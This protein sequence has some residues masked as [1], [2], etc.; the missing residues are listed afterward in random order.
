MTQKCEQCGKGG[1]AGGPLLTCDSCDHGYHGTCVEPPQKTK[2]DG[3]WNCPRCLVGDGNFGFEEGGLYSLKQFQEK[4]SDFKVGYFEN[5]MPFDPVLNCLRPVTEDDVEREFW[6]LVADL[7]ETV[8]VEYGADIHCTTHG[9]GFPTSERNPDN[10]Y[11]TDPWNLNILPLHPESLFRYIKSDISGMT[12][13]WVYVG[14]IFSTFCWHAEDHWAYS[15]NYQHFGATKTWYGIPGEDAEK[16]EA[17]MREAVPE[18]FE[19]QPDLLFQ[20]VT[21]LTPEQLKKAGVRVYALDQRAGQ[22]VITFPRAYHAGFNHGFNFNEA[23]NFAP[24]DW[25]P[26][27]LLGVQ[28]LRHFRRQPCFSHDELLWTAAE[29]IASAGLT[30][31]TAKWLYPALEKIHQREVAERELF[32][33]RH[34]AHEHK[35]VFNGSSVRGNEECP[36]TF[37]IDDAEVPEEEYG[38]AYCKAYTFLSR[39]KCLKSG[40]VLCLTHAGDHP[41]CDAREAD[42][43]LGKNHVLFYRKADN[44]IAATLRKVEDKAHLPEAWM[45][46]YERLL[47]EEA[48]P[49]LKA[50]RGLLADGEK[51]PYELPQLPNLR[52]FVERCNHWVEE[53]MGY[54]LRKQQNRRKSEKLWPSSSRK[55]IGHG[56]HEQKERELR[57]VSNVYRLL[58]EAEQIGFDCPEIVQLQERAEAI[59]TFQANAKKALDQR[60]A[61][62]AQQ[63]EELLEEGQAFSVDIPEVERLTGLLERLRWDEKARANRGVFMSLDE[64]NQLIEDGMRLQIPSYNDHM[65]HYREQLSLGQNWERKAQEVINAETIHFPQLQ[66]LSEQAQGRVLP[67]SADTLAKV[68]QIL[69]K[70]REAHRHIVD[71]NQRLLEPDYRKRPKYAEVSDLVKK[72][73]EIQAKPPG[74]HELE[75]EQRRHEDWMRKGK[76]L[77]GKTNAPLHIL[78]SHMEYVHDRNLDCFNINEDKPRLPAEPASREASPDSSDKTNRWEDAR[79]REVFCICRRVEAGMMIECEVCH[80]WY[81]GKCLKIARGKVKEDDKY[82]CPICDWNVRIPRDATRPKLEDLEAWRDEIPALPFQPEEEE[83]LSRIID[84]ATEFRKHIAPLCNPVLSTRSE[85]ETQRFYLRKIEGAEVLLVFEYN[86]FRQELHKWNPIA[87]RPPPVLEESKST[88]KP[89]P[90]KLQKMLLQYG[91]DDPD[92]LPE[93]VRGKAN[94]LKRKAIQAEAAAAQQQQAAAAAQAGG[95]GTGTAL[96]SPHMGSTLTSPGLHNPYGGGGATSA[97]YSRNSSV[98]PPTPGL[99]S[100]ASSS[101]LNARPSHGADS[102]ASSSSHQG[103]RAEPT[104]ATATATKSGGGGMVDLNASA[105]HPAFFGGAAQLLVPGG[106]DDG[107]QQQMLSLEE[108]LLLRDEDEDVDGAAALGAP[109][110]SRENALDIFARTE[111]GRQR[112]EEIYGRDVW[113][114]RKDSGPHPPAGAGAVGVV[115]A[116]GV[117]S[118]VND[119]IG[120]GAEEGESMDVDRMFG[121]LVNQ[122]EDEESGGGKR[123]G[124]LV[125]EEGDGLG[126]GDGGEVAA[127]LDAE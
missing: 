91:V 122:D 82:T 54:V 45:E 43:Y 37:T 121:E 46:R 62:T 47:E 101:A 32:I 17:A 96:S 88:R 19:T 13:P 80:E 50:L 9:S 21:L 93:E 4:A 42:R 107:P 16:F 38:C 117:G 103:G 44:V 61:M 113:D 81:H 127:L 2:P 119:P 105:I 116:E 98:Q 3:E 49:S 60:Q 36:L 92:H 65:E 52:R 56:C 55:S 35:C 115:K 83:V 68:D 114:R 110:V 94:S 10:P 78:K 40:K 51:I 1:E 99:S 84:T 73:E 66:A 69:A 30:I 64:V 100:V 87:A 106:H 72:L 120:I 124:S 95:T 8:E 11:S 63:V 123:L 76:K 48:R 77:F 29:G 12:V 33:N 102:S 14:M 89:R 41:C 27:G 24:R 118:E 7:E 126:E 39:F 59:K 23:V 31:P 20:L 67:V 57:N 5:K 28:T 34:V 85:A 104:T 58:D 109:L 70:Q 75:R 53:A 97:F 86:F 15:A 26:Y 18:L 71:L 25:E 112:A 74:T 125:K 22:F 90:T 108:R 111:H 6:R 79:F